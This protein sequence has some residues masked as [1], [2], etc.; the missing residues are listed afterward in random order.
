[1]ARISVKKRTGG[2]KDIFVNQDVNIRFEGANSDTRILFNSTTNR[3]ELRV[4]GVLEAA[5]G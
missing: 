1:M 2:P 5:W 4:N 3:F